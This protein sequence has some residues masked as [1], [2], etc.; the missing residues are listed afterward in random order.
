MQHGFFDSLPLNV[1]DCWHCWNAL[2]VPGITIE[3]PQNLTVN[4]LGFEWD[5][6]F[7]ILYVHSIFLA[8]QN[9]A[10]HLIVDW[11]VAPRPSQPL[12]ECGTLHQQTDLRKS[13]FFQATLTF[14][15]FLGLFFLLFSCLLTP[16]ASRNIQHLEFQPWNLW[17]S[18]IQQ[19]SCQLWVCTQQS[20]NGSL[21]QAKATS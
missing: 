19:L 6:Y 15:W 12:A 9:S 17:S 7:A 3:R 14:S 2:S 21:P 13:C 5:T 18:K 10:L 1:M 4:P 8:L 11:R 16:S 20:L